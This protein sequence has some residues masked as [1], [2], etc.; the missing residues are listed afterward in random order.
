MIEAGLKAGDIFTWENYP[1]FVDV[2]KPRRWFLYLGNNNVQAI[3]YQ[4]S[5]TTQFDYYRDGGNR[6]KHNFF[7]L[8]A[9]MGG[10]D[11]E[12]VLD[13][14]RYFEGIPESLFNKFKTDIEKKGTLTQDYINKFIKHLK[15]DPKI[16]PFIKNDICG[17]LRDAGFTVSHKKNAF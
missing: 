9:G 5:T 4:I 12:S 14:T 7:I 16:Q 3:V 8:P 13:L 2:S 6:L 10:L 11:K 1:L 15:D 17:Y